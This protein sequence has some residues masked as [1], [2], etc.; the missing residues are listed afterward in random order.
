MAV[1][2]VLLLYANPALRPTLRQDHLL[3]GRKEPIP[4]LGSEKGISRVNT[5]NASGTLKPSLTRASSTTSTTSSSAV[6]RGI[7]LSTRGF[8][9]SKTETE[10]VIEALFNPTIFTSSPAVTPSVPTP[11]GSPIPSTF[12][13]AASRSKSRKDSKKKDSI[14]GKSEVD[15]IVEEQDVQA[16]WRRKRDSTNSTTSNPNR[17]GSLGTGKTILEAA[18]ELNNQMDRERTLRPRLTPSSGENWDFIL[19]PDGSQGLKRKSTDRGHRTDT[20]D[21]FAT[22]FSTTS[23]KS[24]TST[25]TPSS[26]G[27]NIISPVRA[28]SPVSGLPSISIIAG[29]P[30]ITTPENLPSRGKWYKRFR[31]TS[32]EGSPGNINGTPTSIE[33]RA[34]TPVT[35]DSG[36]NDGKQSAEFAK[37][38]LPS[39]GTLGPVQAEDQSGPQL[40]GG[41]LTPTPTKGA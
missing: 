37:L 1:A 28:S 38:P 7:S 34:T 31:R 39:K 13:E 17:H 23:T 25:S 30:T 40:D 27:P 9:P 14:G 3:I 11:S 20:G 10:A 36:I 4:L 33:R 5:S 32:F 2:T 8:P 29:T 12:D 15:V 24:Y 35:F 26:P 22:D 6:S 21:S 41:Q 19:F 18:L 16:K